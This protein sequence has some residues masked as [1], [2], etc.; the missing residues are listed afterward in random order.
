MV[1][2]DGIDETRTE[3]DSLGAVEVPTTH[4]WGA[5]TQRALA[6]FAISNERMPT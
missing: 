5:Q 2:T 3:R 4:L 6:H 1:R